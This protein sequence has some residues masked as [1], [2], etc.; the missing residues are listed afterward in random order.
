M[1]TKVITL[2]LRVALA[3][4]FLYAGVSKIW[5]FHHWAS[6]T[7]DF[8]IAIQRFQIIP[9]P[10][11]TMLLAIYLP[12][13]E[14]IAAI[15]LFLP[16]L[17]LGALALINVITLIFLGALTSAWIRGI[18]I[19]CNCFGREDAPSNNYLTPIV[20][21]LVILAVAAFLLWRES[22]RAPASAAPDTNPAP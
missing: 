6:A 5:D 12:W 3:A 16:R 1:A 15:A 9:W 8:T 17:R 21:D 4:I 10:E 18:K 11:V 20:R 2:V 7:P 14:V 13:M 22:R 19:S